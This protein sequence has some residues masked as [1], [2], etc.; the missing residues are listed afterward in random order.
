MKIFIYNQLKYYKSIQTALGTVDL[1][2]DDWQSAES[3]RK[4]LL[5]RWDDTYH[6][7]MP[8]LYI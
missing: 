8:F 5:S 6:L 1:M 4:E 2:I 7:D 3:D